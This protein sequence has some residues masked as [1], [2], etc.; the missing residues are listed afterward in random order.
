MAAQS[1]SIIVHHHQFLRMHGRK[2]S[3]MMPH[4]TCAPKER[5]PVREYDLSTRTVSAASDNKLM[6][7][8]IF[9]A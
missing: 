3:N 2:I 4:Q 8:R 9:S 6:T 7:Q 5:D 1:N